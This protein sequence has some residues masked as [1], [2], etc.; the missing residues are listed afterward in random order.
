MSLEALDSSSEVSS[1][2]NVEVAA[3]EVEVAETEGWINSVNSGH[4]VRAEGNK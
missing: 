3:S 1:V 4:I 2:M